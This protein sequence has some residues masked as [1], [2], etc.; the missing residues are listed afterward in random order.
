MRRSL[1]LSL[2]S[3]KKK[4]G[5]ASKTHFFM[6]L[7]M[8]VSTT[9]RLALTV[10]RWI[11][12]VMICISSSVIRSFYPTHRGCLPS[13]RLRISLLSAGRMMNVQTMIQNM[14][15]VMTRPMLEIPACGEKANPPKLVEVFRAP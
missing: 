13:L 8:A 11:E 12:V 6:A 15:M 14:P 2:P 3:K 1:N 9:H 4:D 10:N 5:S 7:V